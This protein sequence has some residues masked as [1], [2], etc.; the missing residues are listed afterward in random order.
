MW[1][2]RIFTSVYSRL[3]V[4][5]VNRLK[6]KYPKINF[7]DS[8]P[9]ASD[10]K[11]PCVVVRRLDSGGELGQTLEGNTI[12][13]VTSGIQIDVIDNQK[14]SNAYAIAD[15]CLDMMKE[16]RYQQIGDIIPDEDNT[17]NDYRC[18]TRFRRVIAE[19]DII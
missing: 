15:V 8:T 18:I 17:L 7:V 6:T 14:M 2:S 9:S 4:N 5:G 12:N 10:I 16:M 19:G 1:T 13:A 3:K 11:Y